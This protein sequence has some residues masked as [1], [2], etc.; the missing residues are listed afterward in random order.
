MKKI[1]RVP[2]REKNEE[3]RHVSGCHGFF[4][5]DS[6]AKRLQSCKDSLRFDSGNAAAIISGFRPFSEFL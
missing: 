1:A 4:G 5:A 3:S 2:G 6:R